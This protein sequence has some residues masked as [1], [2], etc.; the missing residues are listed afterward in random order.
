MPTAF[1][2]RARPGTRRTRWGLWAA[3]GVFLATRLVILIAAYT[4]PQDRTPE[5]R[6]KWAKHACAQQDPEWWPA[7]PLVTWDAG[8]YLEIMRNGYPRELRDTA[9]FFPA[10]PLLARAL[11]PVVALAEPWY[12][13]NKP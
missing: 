9:A 3:V 1:T 11:E 10:Y 4:A 6:A 2:D 8:H 5:E 12:P 13:L 7:V